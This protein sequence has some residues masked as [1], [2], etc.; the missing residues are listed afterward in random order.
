MTSHYKVVYELQKQE[1]QI[2]T[3]LKNAPKELKNANTICAALAASLLAT[4]TH[5]DGIDQ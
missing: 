1:I 3:L 4:I 2:E 5:I